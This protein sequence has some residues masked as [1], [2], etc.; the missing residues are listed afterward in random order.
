[1]LQLMSHSIHTGLRSSLADRLQA[2]GG[3]LAVYAGVETAAHFGDVEREFGAITAGV[4]IYD[5]GWRAKIRAS[6]EDRV[7]WLNGMVTNNVKDLA[8]GHGNYNFVLSAQGRIL[9][10]VYVYNRGE[11]LLLDTERSQAEPL[12]KLLNH[13]IIM[14]DVE[15]TDISEELTSVGVQ[16]P[17]AEALLKQIG[18][19]PD[20]ADPLVVCRVK[21][22]G[23]PLF[24]TRMVN[25]DFV[26]FELWLAPAAANELWEAMTGAGATPVG[27]DALEKFRVM[28]GVPRYGVD[29][30]ER[31]LPQETNQQGA[32]NFSKG[33]YIGQEIVERIRAR[34]QVHRGLQGFILES[35]VSPGAKVEVEGKGLGEITSVAKVRPPGGDAEK[36]LALGYIRREAEKPGTAVQ[37]AGVRGLVAALPFKF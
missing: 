26:T 33:C 30:T 20:C 32:L 5:L 31:Y 29:I 15:L 17:G 12:L 23:H 28:A 35:E 7:R 16:G 8:V 22:N 9:G 36:V 11:E 2:A 27:T 10:D 25:P 13:F 19:V 24:I 14:D 6:G 21:W 34:G 1:M 3:I 18:I 37:V 4:G